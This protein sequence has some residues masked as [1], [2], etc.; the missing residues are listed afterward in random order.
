MIEITFQKPSV[1]R[2]RALFFRRGL[3]VLRS[4]VYERMTRCGLVGRVLDFG[5][6]ALAQYCNEVGRWAAPRQ[7]IEYQSANIDPAIQPT[8]LLEAGHRLPPDTGSFDAVMSLSTLEH[9][10]E[11]DEAL[12]ELSR[13]LKRGG[14]LIVAVPFMFRVHGHPDDYRRGTPSFWRQK[15]GEAGFDNV[16]VEALA[17][18]PFSSGQAVSGLPGPFKAVRRHA[19]LLLDILWC[20]YRYRGM[21]EVVGRQDDAF[22]SAPLGYFME[23]RKASAL[24]HAI[25]A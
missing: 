21:T 22:L 7:C 23:A 17:W 1:A 25:G 5:G 3:S 15:L 9:I 8:Y 6:G 2:Y 20:A 12:A 11:L 13:V 18:G 10:Y 19:G 14:R 24:S 16:V 4:L